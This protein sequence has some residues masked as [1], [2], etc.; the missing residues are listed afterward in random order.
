MLIMRKT[1]QHNTEATK[2]TLRLSREAIEKE[3]PL[4]IDVINQLK[5]LTFSKSKSNYA[6]FW[7]NIPTETYIFETTDENVF[8]AAKVVLKYHN[9]IAQEA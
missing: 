6:L 9:L 1:M 4:F 8:T 3:R 2:Y 7:V 5:D